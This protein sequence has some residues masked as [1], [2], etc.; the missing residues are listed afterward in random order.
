EGVSRFLNRLWT[1]V[2]DSSVQEIPETKEMV[3]LRHK[4]VYDIEQRFNQF[5]LNT[6]I[7][8]FMEYNNKLIDLAKT[9]GGIDRETLKTLVI[10]I[11]PFA[12]HIGEELWQ[13]LGGTDTVFHEQ[14]PEY[15]E[16]AM[17]DDQI[18]IAVQVN[19]KTKAIISLPAEVSK[20]DAITVGKA[21]VLDK[22]TGTVVKEIYVPG[23]IVNLVCK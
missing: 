14:W 4:L 9:T 22:L 21:A 11:A 2:M 17:K 3:K 16:A 5:S 18:E 6:V 13:Q 15:D 12:P 10:L 23:K 7:S 19:G 20:E 8:G 1:L